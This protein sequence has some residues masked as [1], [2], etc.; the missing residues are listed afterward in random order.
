M[1]HLLQPVSVETNDTEPPTRR[2]RRLLSLS[3]AVCII[4]AVVYG[5][6]D[7]L[8]AE[9]QAKV[10]AARSEMVKA[11]AT[12]NNM[13]LLSEDR[14]KE[15]TSINTGVPLSELTFKEISLITFD[16]LPAP[17]QL[18]KN[19]ANTCNVTSQD[20]AGDSENVVIP[21]E[22][23]NVT[24]LPP[25]KVPEKTNATHKNAVSAKAPLIEPI[26]N[27]EVN[28]VPVN[29]NSEPKTRPANDFSRTPPHE[30]QKH[31]FYQI[32]AA[33]SGLTYE[34]IIDGVNGHIIKS[35][36]H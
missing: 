23:G 20:D 9:E 12:A 28:N 2:I 36:V 19:H 14:I 10:T 13:S 33:R 7:Y 26:P 27:G 4:G 34:L 11:Q 16:D 25:L 1:K 32:K 35:I 6:H 21:E 18:S 22:N 30:F 5:I 17:S 31:P 15:L 29:Q 8:E 3:I 24:S